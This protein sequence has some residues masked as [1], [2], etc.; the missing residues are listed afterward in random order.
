MQCCPDSE[1]CAR[2]IRRL[3]LADLSPE[4]DIKS[5]ANL[6]ATQV[7]SETWSLQL[8][9]PSLVEAGNRHW[10]VDT[11]SHRVSLTSLSQG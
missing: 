9:W 8:A 6:Y 5:E 3:G 10:W 11:R 1:R 7:Q 2:V 4:A